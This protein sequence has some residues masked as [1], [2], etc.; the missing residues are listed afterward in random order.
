MRFET[1]N[2]AIQ[3][4]N[5]LII[6]VFGALL[7]WLALR[8]SKRTQRESLGVDGSKIKK[9]DTI[10]I[11]DVFGPIS[12]EPHSIPPWARSFAAFGGPI[13]R[14]L[15]RLAE[16]DKV[17]GVLVRY[18]TP[19]GTVP[20]SIAINRGIAAVSAKKP[21]FGH[22]LSY[23]FSGGM[24]ASVAGDKTYV[25]EG[26]LVG[27]IGVV[28]P[29]LFSYSDVSTI[30]GGVLR[31]GVSAGTIKARVLA[32][33]KG[34]AF[35]NPFQPLDT[36]AA[37][38]FTALLEREYVR[39]KGHV[40]EGRGIPVESVEAIGA[41]VLDQSEAEQIGLIDGVADE[42]GV[43]Q[44]LAEKLDKKVDDLQFVRVRTSTGPSAAFS[45]ALACIA[46]VFGADPY[47]TLKS[48]MRTSPIAVISEDWLR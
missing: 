3:I 34:K 5:W 36:E 33:G 7:C 29:T 48:A 45:S 16:N 15:K 23:C 12:D 44:L 46:A 10:A 26:A 22:V 24:L 47:A 9:S 41:Y 27:S 42:E 43:K 6:I 14:V 11:V 20:G 32:A 21:V 18:N 25:Q 13:G 31:G 35:G 4:T 2:F 1:A 37:D 28:G 38:H 19:G 30:D 39:F 8:A 40:S 17:V